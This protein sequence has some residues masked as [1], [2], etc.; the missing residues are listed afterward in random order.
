MPKRGLIAALLLVAACS[1]DIVSNAPSGSVPASRG[2]SA[3]DRRFGVAGRVGLGVRGP[4][5][6]SVGERPADAVARPRRH[7][8][9]PA[10]LGDRGHGCRAEPPCRPST[11]AARTEILE[12]GQV[13]I[14]S[15]YDGVFLG[16]G[17]VRKAY[18]WYHVM[19]L[20]TGD[21]DGDLPALPHAADPRRDRGR[22]RMD[23][24]RQQGR[25]RTSR[26]CRRGVPRW[27]TWRT[28][29]GCWPRSASRALG[30][31]PIVLEGT[32]GCPNCGAELQGDFDPIWLNYPQSLDFLSVN[33]SQ[34]IGPV[35]LRFPP[36]GP[37]R[38]AGG[39]II[40][41]TVHVDDP[42]ADGCSITIQGEA[43]VPPATAELYCREQLVVDSYE[44]IGMDA[45]F[46]G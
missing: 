7:S 40:R 24:D 36:D 5:L 23:R 17:P 18:T 15:P 12:R 14:V 20:Q 26:R 1:P 45:G 25:S 21:A 11:S 22:G 42:A 10:R 3:P 41:V 32:F 13:L 43:P 9:P 34:D 6:G 8:C 31:V 2:A 39:S 16:A 29:R 27:S 46:G 35:V 30:A 33:A 28:S 4:E 38:P 19:K 37:G 44:V